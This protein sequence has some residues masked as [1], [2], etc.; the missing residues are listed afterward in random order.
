M[1]IL[2]L[3]LLKN[4]QAVEDVCVAC[5]SSSEPALMVTATSQSSEGPTSAEP[6]QA[7]HVQKMGGGRGA[8]GGGNDTRLGP[9]KS[10]IYIRGHLKLTV[11][12]DSVAVITSFMQQQCSSLK[13]FLLKLWWFNAAASRFS[14]VIS[15]RSELRLSYAHGV[16]LT[17]G[18]CSSYQPHLSE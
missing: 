9:L 16:H 4:Q 17:E 1:F 12:L 5:L 8:G 11:L 2:Y 7:T 10:D 6:R 14:L 15:F 13:A 18:I 3:I